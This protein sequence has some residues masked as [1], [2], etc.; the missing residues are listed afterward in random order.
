MFYS[1]F[2]KIVGLY[3]FLHLLNMIIILQNLIGTDEDQLQANVD[4]RWFE[5]VLLLFDRN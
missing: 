1:I 2:L 5:S 4:P 3:W